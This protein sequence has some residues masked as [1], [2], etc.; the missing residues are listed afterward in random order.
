MLLLLHYRK[1]DPIRRLGS[2]GSTY[3]C[4]SFNVDFMF[5]IMIKLNYLDDGGSCD[6]INDS[7]LDRLEPGERCVLSISFIVIT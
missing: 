1:K 2:I 7:S 5:V 3:L 4:H 6:A